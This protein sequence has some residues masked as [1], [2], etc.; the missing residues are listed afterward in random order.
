LSDKPN[1]QD[2]QQK[3]AERNAESGVVD[4]VG[5]ISSGDDSAGLKRGV[6]GSES[7]FRQVVANIREVFWIGTPDWK[8]MLYISPAYEKVWGRS[9][10]SLYSRPLDW[11]DAVVDADREQVIDAIRRKSAGDFSDIAFPEYRILLPDGAERWICARAFPIRDAE[12]KIYR[13]AGIAEDITKRKQAEL[14]LRQERDLNRRYLDTAQTLMVALD[15]EGRVT[16]INRA[17]CALLG[18]KEDELLGRNWFTTC[19]PQHDHVPDKVLSIFNKLWAGDFDSVEYVENPVLCRDGSERL[20]AWHNTTL[21][22]ERGQVIGAL[23]SGVDITARKQVENA[24][25]ENENLLTSVIGLLPVGVWIVDVEGKLDSANIAAQQIWAGARY[26]GI[27]QF[28]E[29][30]GWWCNSKKPIEPHEWAAARAIEKGATSIDEEIK[31][32]CF[33]GTHKIILNSGL[34]IR[35]SDGAISGAIVVNQ[36]IT[37]RKQAEAE[38]RIAAAAFESQEGMMV[39]DANKV[40]LKVNRAFTEITG[41]TAEEVV[42]QT[43]K[44][45]RSDRHNEGFYRAMWESIH[46]AGGWQ[47]E[48]WDRRKNGEIYPIWLTITAVKSDNGIVTH[49]VGTHTDITERKAADEQIAFLAYHDTLTGL[50]NR[51]LLLDR[52]KQSLAASARS[53]RYGALFLFDLDNFKTLNDTLGHDKGDLLLQ[54][55]AQRLLTCVREGDTVARLGGDE[56]VVMLDS[57]SESSE[58]TATQAE[59]VGVKMLAALNQPYLIASNKIRST[60]SIGVTLFGGHQNELDELLKQADLAMY[61]SKTAGRNTLHFFDPKTQALVTDRA[62]LEADLRE[63]LRQQQFA[64]YY[65]AQVVGDGRLIGAEALV[66]WQHPQRGLVLPAEFIPMAEE[67]GLILPLGH[68]VLETACAQ[69]VQWAAQPN[70]AHL[71]LAVNVSA[72]QLHQTDFVDQVLGVIGSTGANPHRLKLELTES[73]LV[74]NVET[75]IAKMNALKAHGVGFAL[76]DFGTGYS[77]LSYL[78]RLPLDLLKIDQSFVMDILIDPNDAAIARMVIA[79]AE[80]LGLAVIAE[81]VE[82]DAQKDFLARL[83]CHAYQGY[84]FGRPLPLD[85]FEEFVK[86]I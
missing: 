22:D 78:K 11:L 49:Y 83:G 77:S 27:E 65:Q 10:E 12:G 34:P 66:R 30:K 47:G 28:G 54:Q 14:A 15:C 80:S 69:L 60:P 68:W 62:T 19:L 16:M 53:G 7:L 75:I 58:E 37:E 4:H 3:T 57:L 50:P 32:E 31:I 70:T 6:R 74:S 46:Q 51:L 64:I 20:I 29:Y 72:S 17:G 71:T 13:V 5:A 45:L 56:F 76:D 81:G 24:L 35:G 25:R 36:D 18:Y 73:L 85:K 2:L 43:P 52:L 8:E 84:L 1:D 21:C 59:T 55:V 86:R 48:V 63:G 26:V 61:Q 23:G 33:D 38:L 82:I 42:G 9:C 40:I 67:T 41:Y 39:T 79:L 44:F